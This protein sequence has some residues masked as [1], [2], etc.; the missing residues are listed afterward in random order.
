MANILYTLIIYP[1]ALIIETSYKLARAVCGDR[2][3]AVIGVSVAVS[4]LC[5]P[6][7]IV[8]EKWQQIERDKQKE[9]SPGID[10][11]KKAFKGDEQYMVLTTFYK[12]KRYHPLM[13]LRSSFGLLIQI[14]F[15]IAAY[16]FLSNLSV[17]QGYSFF[18][19]RDMGKPDALFSIGSFP[20]NVLPIAMTI[21]NIAGSAVYTK[22]FKLK[23]KLPIYAMAL[24]FLAILYDSPSGLVL[25]WTM[26]NVFSLV[27]N[28]FYKIK[29][30]LL[31]LYLLAC[32]AAATGIFRTLFVHNGLFSKRVVLAFLL[33][34][35]F[36]TPLIV[37][38]AAWAIKEPLK[39]LAQNKSLRHSIFLLCALSL[40]LL[41]GLV[42]PSYTISSSVQEFVDID[43]IMNPNRYIL[44]TLVQSLGFFV[45]WLCCVYFLFGKKVQTLMA[46][47]AS[48]ALLWA[49]ANAFAFG[50]NYGILSR[51]LIFEKTVVDSAAAKALN[52]ATLALL[53]AA[54]LA[55][56]KFPKAKKTLLSVFSIAMISFL[57]MGTI[58][59]TKI[60]IESN[61]YAA[62]QVHEEK[63]I[64]PI[65][66]FSKEG[67]NVVVIM[68]DR[69]ESACLLPIFEA[70]PELEEEYKDWTFYSHALSYD[71]HT[72]LGAPP[73]Y[74][75]Y[76]Y[77]PLEMNKRSGVPLKEKNNEA[78]LL[79]PRVFTE[80]A[81]FDCQAVDLSWA[82]YNWI[83]DMTICDP[84]PK[85]K[86]YNL[87]K[88]HAS[89]WI[90]EHPQNIRPNA[91]SQ[92]IK[93]NFLWFA[94]F[95]ISPMFLRES[96]YDDGDWWTSDDD[97]SDIIDYIAKYSVL[98][99]LPDL[100]D[101]TGGPNGN[102][103]LLESMLTH[104]SMD[105]QAPDFVPSEKITDK[106]KFGAYS[107]NDT[108]S[109]NIAMLKLVAKWMD[110][111]RKN[112]CYD[113][114]RI[115]IVADHGAG[116]EGPREFFTEGNSIDG[117]GLDQ[118]HPLLMVKD[119]TDKNGSGKNAARKFTVDGSFMTN[120]DTP[121]LAFEGI[122]EKP[123]NP[124]T[125][126]EITKREESAAYGVVAGAPY[127]PGKHGLYKFDL[128]GI[129]VY[130]VFDDMSKASNWKERKE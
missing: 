88:R 59:A 36:F 85:I 7:Y 122:I 61:K 32:A 128:D 52:A 16:S 125:G 62:R 98:D 80:Q 96:I 130:D 14:P 35:I 48:L 2:G 111:L 107:Y 12:Q 116:R 100:T 129:K 76:E 91:T 124:W 55:A 40:A 87:E 58:N 60:Q 5:L 63:D 70:Y 79:M 74:G 121:S 50:G 24:V 43:G 94:F 92:A 115:I 109:T 19:I 104:T 33:S 108:V 49:A 102:F 65:F 25:Y 57:A 45:F 97:F 71:S 101:F 120:G 99:Y 90:S 41:T 8:A 72:L 68:S 118:N 11:I 86:G 9:M 3:F 34:L 73:L 127:D 42:I 64:K 46:F 28:I 82:N 66:H 113:N 83:P 15:F 114:T 84:Y 112:G 77:T 67:K 119:F 1:L 105:L 10:R 29:R 13:A 93:R 53:T 26:N 22:G 75:G 78:L 27:K 6:L 123:V 4:L 106:G 17:L 81:G 31:A 37:K 21:I 20:V 51:V 47:A 38:A 117:Y 110:Y 95:K 18:F 30:P 69:A 39:E 89:K 103:I 44:T 54:L 23:E 56:Y 126:K